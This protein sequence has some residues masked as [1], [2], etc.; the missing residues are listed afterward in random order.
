MKTFYDE[1]YKMKTIERKGWKM[2]L[3][4]MEIMAKEDL[5]LDQLKVLKMV[6]IHE[7]C[8]LDAGDHT[9]R[10]S[11]PVEHKKQM[12]L[13]CIERISEDY[14][15]PEIINLYQEFEEVKTPEANFVKMLD[16]LDTLNQAQIY[17]DLWHK[18]SMYDDFYSTNFEKVKDFTKYLKS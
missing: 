11:R 9:P 4:A 16:K 12:E 3:L 6:L 8:E 13:K 18:Q 10:D 1:L 7:L 17:S 14:N 5:R 15:L 2:A